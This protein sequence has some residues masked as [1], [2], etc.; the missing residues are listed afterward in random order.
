MTLQQLLLSELQD[1]SIFRVAMQSASLCWGIQALPR[2]DPIGVRRGDELYPSCFAL[3]EF[4]FCA[5]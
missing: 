2:S 4:C 3:A 5:T 1:C